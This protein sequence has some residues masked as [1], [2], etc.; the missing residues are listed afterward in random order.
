MPVQSIT[1]IATHES[2]DE[3][4][5]G[6]ADKGIARYTPAK[7]QG[8]AAKWKL[9][10]VNDGMLDAS[11]KSLV[12]DKYQHVYAAHAGGISHFNG[13]NWERVNFKKQDVSSLTIDEENNIWI[14]TNEGAWKHSPYYANAKGRSLFKKNKNGDEEVKVESKRGTWIH[15]HTGNGLRDKHVAAIRT[16]GS[17]VWFLT[18]A[19]VERYN[20]AKSQ[21]GFF[22]E[23]LLPVLNLPDLYH[24]YAGG[25]FPIE[26]WGTLGGFVNFVSFGQ[27]VQ[28][29]SDGQE[30]GN[31]KAYEL[32]SG[33]SYGTRLTPKLGLGINAKFIYSALAQG[34][35]STGENTDGVAASYAVDLGLLYKNLWI[36]GFS[37]GFVMQNMG[38]AVFYVDQAQSDPIPFTWKLGLA[39][40]VIH[41]TD[42]RLTVG[43]DVNR[44]AV[45]R[46][47]DEP[48]PF[49]E[50]SWKALAFPFENKD[51]GIASTWTENVRQSVFNTGAEYSYANVVAV[52]SGWLYDESGKRYEI[53]LGLGFMISD[54]LQVDGTFIR[55][56][57]EGIRNNQKRFSM[58]LRF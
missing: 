5:V 48:A 41:T 9:Y 32:V 26:E 15:Y 45:Y 38:P 6:L 11:V 20:S 57:G 49:Y 30:I 7:K 8:D 33:L 51:H 22:Y 14:G 37:V 28:T 2:V 25:T 43:A 1:A 16:Q 18:G 47:G 35:T 40:E 36:K 27:N 12:V 46:D 3:V 17:D 4:Y 58:V 13:A 19:G 54:I 34:I 23:S 55:S 44:E 24:A 50:G 42:H 52:R 56:L 53:D 10:G 21:V 29:N 31:F 39:Y